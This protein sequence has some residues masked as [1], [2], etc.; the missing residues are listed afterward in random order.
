[1]QVVINPK[2][3]AGIKTQLRR[4]WE[5]AHIFEGGINKEIVVHKQVIEIFIASNY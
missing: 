5:T 1:M 4:G 2:P 3:N